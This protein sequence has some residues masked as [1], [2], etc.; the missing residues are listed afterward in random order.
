MGWPD[1]YGQEVGPRGHAIYTGWVN[2]SGLPALALPCEPSREG[3]PIG[4]Q[5][6]GAY[7]A[8]D[9]LLD[10]GSAYEAAH[11]WAGRWPVLS[12]C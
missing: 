10:L 7:G 5:M 9:M 8:D 6:V 11:P 1:A 4:M 3:L 2:A 12:A